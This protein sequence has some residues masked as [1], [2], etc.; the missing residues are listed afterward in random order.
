MVALSLLFPVGWLVFTLVRGALIG[1]YPYPFLQVGELGYG[2]VAL[3]SAGITL[4]FLGLAACY[5][6]IDRFLSRRTRRA[7]EQGT[8]PGAKID[9]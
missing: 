2:R 6:G 1:W 9:A 7:D 4:L 5:R 3:N 8:E